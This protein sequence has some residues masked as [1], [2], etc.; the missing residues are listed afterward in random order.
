MADW[1][2]VAKAA[3]QKIA[4]EAADTRAKSIAYYYSSA[5]ATLSGGKEKICIPHEFAEEVAAL[6]TLDGCRVL[7]IA[8]HS[9]N[10][11]F[12]VDF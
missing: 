10:D 7:H 5:V 12:K 1:I 4:A 9:G 3:R 11:I 6:L 8:F 2:S